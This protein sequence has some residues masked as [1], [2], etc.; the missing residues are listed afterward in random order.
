MGHDLHFFHRTGRPGWAPPAADE[1]QRWA[2]TQDHMTV[3]ATHVYYRNPE[4]GT[5][6]QIDFSTPG[7][8]AFQSGGVDTGIRFSLNY[9]RPVFFAH[10]A[11]PLVAEL[12][13]S[14]SLLILDP[15][16]QGPAEAR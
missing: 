5:D 6:F 2:R 11:I 9:A 16:S 10:E 8:A 3:A 7:N 4:T 14:Q 12:A 15:Q 1:V 13:K